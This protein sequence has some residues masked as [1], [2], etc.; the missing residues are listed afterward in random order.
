MVISSKKAYA[1]YCKGYGQGDFERW[2]ASNAITRRTNPLVRG[3][4]TLGGGLSSVQN[5]YLFRR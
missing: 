3:T 5:H 4:R 2:G 1:T